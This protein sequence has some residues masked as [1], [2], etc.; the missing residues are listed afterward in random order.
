MG[1]KASLKHQMSRELYAM[2]SPGAK[3]HLDKKELGRPDPEK[4]YSYRTYEAYKDCCHRFAAWAKQT[5]GCRDL[6]DTRQHAAEYLEMRAKTVAASTVHQDCAALAKLYHC[7]MHDLLP[8]L[9]TRARG[10]FIKNRTNAWKGHYNKK[11]HPEITTLSEGCGLRRCE[12]MGLRPDQVVQ[13]ED[14]V[15]IQ[16]VKGKGGK[17]RD[18]P[19]RRD[20]GDKVLTLASAARAAGRDKI[21]SERISSRAPIH[22]DRGRSYAQGLYRELARPIEKL[23]RCEI[24]YARKEMKGQKW[25]KVAMMMVSKALGH[26]RL[27]VITNYFR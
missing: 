21:L 10:D 26:S 23:S 6:T 15:W 11:L 5:Y 25:D 3:K 22:D 8:N 18:V 17:V 20:Y 13:R 7:Q 14:R 1:K 2:L 9:P 19:I 4:I 12:M 16:N 24:Y 27:N